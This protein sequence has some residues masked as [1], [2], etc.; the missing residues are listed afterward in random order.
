MIKLEY[1]IIIAAVN[2]LSLSLKSFDWLRL[3][4]KTAFYINL[5]GQTMTDIQSFIILLLASFMLFGMPMLML[6]FYTT[7]DVKLF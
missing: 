2:S 5:I 6:N 7:P 1:L 4:E 3:I